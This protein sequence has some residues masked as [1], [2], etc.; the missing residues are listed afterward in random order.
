[1]ALVYRRCVASDGSVPAVTSALVYIE[2]LWAR[3]AAIAPEDYPDSM[4]PNPAP[5]SRSGWFPVETG[6]YDDADGN[7]PSG[8][9]IGGL[10][11]I[12]NNWGDLGAHARDFVACPMP[13]DRNLEAMLR[14]AGFDLPTECWRTNAFAG[15]RRSGLIGSIGSTGSESYRRACRR[16]L[17][18]QIGDLQPRVCLA[19]GRDP[20]R[21]VG[22]M[23]GD[24]RWEHFTTFR[25]LDES[26][27]VYLEAMAVG[28]VV[29]DLMAVVHPCIA[30][31]ARHQ[32]WD[33]SNGV[34]RLR[35]LLAL[36]AATVHAD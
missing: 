26:G 15:L 24:P 36:A 6:L 1:M 5:F 22:G 25:Q 19:L 31:N 16:L 27:G 2:Q 28:G 14:T 4:C 8:L 13:T 30:A 23:V 17:A 34:E 7:L 9:P 33:G 11:V 21:M 35:E 10:M 3:V 29:T 32:W 20:I 18:L 12:G